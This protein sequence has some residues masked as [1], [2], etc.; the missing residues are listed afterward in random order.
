MGIGSRQFAVV[1]MLA[2]SPAQ[3]QQ[4]DK[5]TF[6]TNWVAQAE[7]GGFY[8]AVADGT[9]QQARSRRDHPARRA[10]R[11]PP[12]ATARRQASSST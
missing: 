6:A 7:H 8:Q 1:A 3:A 4:L 9:Y 10:E 5:V 12:P 11:E 2:L